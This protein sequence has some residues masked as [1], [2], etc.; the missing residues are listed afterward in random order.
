MHTISVVVF[1]WGEYVLSKTE[2]N[3]IWYLT[4]PKTKNINQKL[5]FCTVG[6]FEKE[7]EHLFINLSRPLSPTIRLNTRVNP[8]FVNIESLSGINN[9]TRLHKQFK[10]I[11]KLILKQSMPCHH[12]RLILPIQAFLAEL[13]KFI[14]YREIGS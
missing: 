8:F 9:K 4:Y 1:I 3:H 2:S 10:V 6:K 14:F 5:Y 12:K 7:K 13:I 11:R